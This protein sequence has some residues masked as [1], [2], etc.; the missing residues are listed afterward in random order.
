LSTQAW[1]S[2]ET[3]EPNEV[4]PDVQETPALMLDLILDALRVNDAT[5]NE[6]AD[7]LLSRFGVRCV[8]RLTREAMNTK[9]RPQHRLRILRAIRRIG[10]A[11][12]DSHVELGALLADKNAEIRTVASDLIKVLNDRR[13]GP[14][15]E[16]IERV[17]AG[18]C[19]ERHEGGGSRPD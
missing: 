12:L 14:I 10:A 1:Q 19:G 11:D 9:I 5:L 3:S 6:M 15:A 4:P 2:I 17:A 8:R 7:E 18:I 16:R 13:I